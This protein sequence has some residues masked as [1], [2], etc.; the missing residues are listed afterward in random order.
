MLALP[1]LLL[2]LALT[3]FLVACESS[4]ER[5]EGHY[6]KGVE[7]LEAGDVDRALVEFRNV[8]RLNGNHLEARVIYARTIRERGNLRDAY[9][10]YLRL[11]EQYPNNLEGRIALSEMAF[12]N[13]NW[14]ELERHGQSALSAAPENPQVQ[15]IAIAL[16]FL[17]RLR[18]DAEADMA[19][20]APRTDALTTEQ[21]D[22]PILL[23][24]QI[25]ILARNGNFDAAVDAVDAT[26][27]A[28]PNNR[29]LHNLRLSL[30]GQLQD[31][32][33]IGTQLLDMTQRFPE[34]DVLKE[35]LIRFYVAQD[36]AQDAED[37]LRS[38]ADPAS[39]TRK[40]FNSLITFV[41]ESK[42]PEAAIAEVEAAIAAHPDRAV[43]KS[44]RAAL[45]FDSGAR[46][47]AISE[48]ETI[49]DGAE[50]SDETRQIQVELAR[51]LI[52]TSN[53]VGAQ[54]LTEAVLAEDPLQ[55]DA[56]LLKA[57]WMI[58]SD[59][60]EGAIALLRSALNERPDDSAAMT[61]M[62][63][64]H[65]RAGNSEL[66]QDF[67]GLA[68]EASGKAPD[69]SIRYSRVLSRN[70]SF[71][72]AED[73]LLSSLR[74]SP[75]NVPILSE[76]GRL[77]LQMEDNGRVR[78][79]VQE[80]SR[81]ETS[82]ANAIANTLTA[83]ILERE[84]GTSAAA[85]FL[86]TLAE[87]SDD[88]IARTVT[89]VRVRLAEGDT[90]GAMELIREAV[91]QNPNESTLQYVQAA[92]QR[93]AGALEDAAASFRK[94][95]EIF[96]KEAQLW[97]ELSRTHTALGETDEAENVVDQGLAQQPDD[98][99]LLWAKASLL[100][101]NGDLPGAIE[102]YE[103]IYERDSS[104]YVVANNLASLL[105]ALTP[106][107][108]AVIDRA[109]SIARRLRDTDIPQFQ[110]TYGRIVFLRGEHE[111]ALKY[112]EPA[113]E[114]LERDAIVQQHLAELYEALGRYEEALAQ[115]IKTRDVAVA[116]QNTRISQSDVEATIAELE[117]KIA[118]PETDDTST[119]N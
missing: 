107:D 93:A 30:L 115:Y 96:P 47:T 57:Q 15:V 101:L 88:A 102:I 9:G 72:A 54:Q 24:L 105:V 79:V 45:L 86:E 70:E 116:T 61:L 83:A 64:A 110:D 10:Q 59:D 67:L 90:E 104:S 52:A 5:A 40:Y 18:E 7:L 48:M 27:K 2:G 14:D 92:V 80:L 8:F 46:D 71:L 6:K 97:L 91:L 94:L 34:D 99:R 78:Q 58:S 56:M 12:Q 4:E 50:P 69:E 111:E 51:M 89:L 36:R 117:A 74:L 77:Y 68:V 41:R 42:G 49:L 82:Q 53:D 119:D 37:F 1:R 25:E 118:A 35:N 44:F 106:E 75:G 28:E 43:L 26:L 32:D 39:E 109:W 114:N 98:S 100:E 17:E 16:E 81:L 13:R 3:L 73:T 76:L 19:D 62:A 63:Q 87:S 84:K 33:R 22:N 103:G 11:I 55:V 113:A 85:S 112:L 29:D 66:A 20:L 31:A 38:I 21:P 60:I 23:R 65:T 108:E 95:T